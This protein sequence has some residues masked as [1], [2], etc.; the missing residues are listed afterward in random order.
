MASQNYFSNPLTFDMILDNYTL[1]NNVFLERPSDNI[2]A[3]PI[4]Y[5]KY[6]KNETTG[7]FELVE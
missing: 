4:R 6:R 1:E 5:Q 7:D 2:L 3:D